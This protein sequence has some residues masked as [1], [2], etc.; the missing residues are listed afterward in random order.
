[1]SLEIPDVSS[2][3]LESTTSPSIRY[4]DL[5]P[6]ELVR[7]IVKDVATTVVRDPYSW[8]LKYSY[9]HRRNNLRALCLVSTRFRLIAQPALL[10]VVRIAIGKGLG[11]GDEEKEQFELVVERNSL[12]ALSA[13]RT[14]DIEWLFGEK[15]FLFPSTQLATLA[16]A[17]GKLQ[18]LS[19]SIMVEQVIPFLG[20]SESLQLFSL[21][22]ATADLIRSIRSDI[23]MLHLYHVNLA[24]ITTISLP[25][26]KYLDMDGCH[27]EEG[28][29]EAEVQFDLPSLRH[30]HYSTSDTLTSTTE[31]NTALF[32]AV[33]PILTSVTI[34]FHYHDLDIFRAPVMSDYPVLD[35]YSLSSFDPD[36]QKYWPKGI[37]CIRYKCYAWRYLTEFRKCMD[38]LMSLVS[39]GDELRTLIL[40][41]D[42]RSA[43][44]SDANWEV[45]SRLEQ[46]CRR[47]GLE[48]VW[49]E[50]WLDEI[51]W[52]NVSPWFIK[53]SE[54]RRE[55]EGW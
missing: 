33:A 17:V 7:Q 47:K 54:A 30:L 5:L 2:L 15:S 52:S 16:Q 34:P 39:I 50:E 21:V 53:Y 27:A 11:Q 37:D 23:V 43:N 31:F 25:R 42:I 44:L 46:L 55:A 14:L 6:P 32:L 35:C 36:A 4:F 26:L 1:M 38:N 12:E 49:E 29:G 24:S 48:I 18:T 3:T 9:E 28:G 41:P 19:C 45:I 22:F 10:E 51:F 20:S 40:Y 8:A 13:I